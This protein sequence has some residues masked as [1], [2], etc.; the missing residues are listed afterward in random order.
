MIIDH[1]EFIFTYKNIK[2]LRLTVKRDKVMVSVPLFMKEKTVMDF[3]Y[4]KLD[5]IKKHMNRLPSQKEISYE[6]GQKVYL[7]NKPYIINIEIRDNNKCY[8]NN[9]IIKFEIKADEEELKKKLLYKLFKKNLQV[10]AD[11]YL[12]EWQNVTGI[13]VSEMRFRRMKTRWGSC[14]IQAKRIW[15]NVNLAGYDEKCLSYVI[16][17]EILHIKEKYHNKRFYTL[18]SHFLPEWKNARKMLNERH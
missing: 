13:K 5:R 8:I 12:K 4:S 16:L 2:R 3:I 11:E 10:K 7:W 14:N 9:N 18:L 17:H 15:L 6:Q 1:I